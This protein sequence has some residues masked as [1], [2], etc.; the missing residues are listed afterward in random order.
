MANLSDLGCS[1]DLCVGVM[2]LTAIRLLKL[3]FTLSKF[4][5]LPRYLNN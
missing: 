3:G 2:F 4:M 1:L 5:L